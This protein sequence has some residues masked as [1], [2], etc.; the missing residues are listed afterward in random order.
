MEEEEGETEEEEEDELVM[1]NAPPVYPN[2]KLVRMSLG[3][4]ENSIESLI[5]QV[6]DEIVAKLDSRFRKNQCRF[7][8][9]RLLDR[10]QLTI[11][12]SEELPE[13]DRFSLIVYG[14]LVRGNHL[15]ADLL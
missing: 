9:D 12:G 5:D 11:D 15:G 13:Q 14:D 2:V 1:S 3:S 6:N 4:A 7:Y 8:Y 10:V